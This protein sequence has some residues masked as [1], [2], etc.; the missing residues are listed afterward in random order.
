MQLG[1]AYLARLLDRYDGS[2]PLAVAAYNAGPH[3]VDAWLAQNGDPRA[4]AGPQ[5]SASAMIDWIERI[6]F[7]ETRN[8]VE[9]VLE[10]VVVYQARRRETRPALLAQ[11]IP[12]A[13]GA[14]APAAGGAAGAAPPASAPTAQAGR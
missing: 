6:P 14:G 5:G 8:Y 3:R 12:P 9:R 7:A 10:N 13:A 2:L 4:K 11:W 1:T